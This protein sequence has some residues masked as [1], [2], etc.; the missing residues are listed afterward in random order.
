MAKFR[1]MSF[2]VYST[3]STL[4]TIWKGRRWSW[5]GDERM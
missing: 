4:N 2:L 3:F 1:K 5:T